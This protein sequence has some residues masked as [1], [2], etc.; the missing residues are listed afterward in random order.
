M[1]SRRI[2]GQAASWTI[3]SISSSA[4]VELFA[5]A[6]ER[7]VGVL[8][9]RYLADFVDVELERDD[10]VPERA[11]DLRDGFGP[12]RELVGDEDAQLP[13][14]ALRHRL[15]P[16]R[17]GAWTRP[18]QVSPARRSRDGHCSRTGDDLR[19]SLTRHTPV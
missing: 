8:A 13:V 11:G 6:D 12:L 15:A 18:E 19:W 14:L 4:C 5:E 17:E 1:S 16:V 9:S 2:T 10:L 3:C 7:D